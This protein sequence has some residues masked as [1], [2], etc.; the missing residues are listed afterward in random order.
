M[1]TTC[2][3]LQ[4]SARWAQSEFDLAD[5]GDRR[6]TTRLVKIAE[7]LARSP[8]G[9]LPQA[10]P[11]WHEVK[12]AYRFFSNGAVRYEDIQQP[13][14]Q[15]TRA[16]CEEAGEYLFIEDTTQLNYTHHPATEDL[17]SLGDGQGRGLLLHSTLAVRVEQWDLNH[18]PEGIVVGL[19]GQRCWTRHGVARRAS[20]TWRQRIARPRESQRWGAVLDELK[21]PPQDCCWIYIADR[22]ADFYEPIERCSRL[23]I[24]FIIRAYRDR[25]VVDHDDHLKAAVARSPV[26][27]Q[28]TVE[29]RARAGQP[30]RTAMV[31][32]RAGNLTVQGPWRPGGRQPDFSVNVVE[33]RE[34]DAPPGVQPLHWLLLTSLPCNRWSEVR[35]VVGR[36]AAR[37]WVED[38]H[39]ALKTGTKVEDSQLARAYRLESL[40]AV[41]AILA[42]RLLNSQ[43]LARTRPEG[44]VDAQVF[45]PQALRILG[46]HFGMPEEGWTHRNVLVCVA[47]IGGFLAR[48]GDGMPGWQTIWRGWLRLLW[49]CQ[50]LEIVNF[51]PKQCG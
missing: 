16:R 15:A 38:Y 5:L 21:R 32:V 9:T 7:Q 39:K 24:H 14:C 43:W 46:M 44:E 11:E 23:G 20:E 29:L 30:A 4:S 22:E 31:A 2:T 6:R 36:Y 35:R 33:A 19:L 3:T 26:L 18:R 42:V 48:R 34:V 1:S 50:G 51:H 27:G 10:M 28:M 37:W 47:R 49:M 25:K 41:L 40:V 12:A 13:H 8:G 17:G 45:G